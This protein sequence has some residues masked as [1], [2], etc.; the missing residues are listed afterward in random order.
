MKEK[1]NLPI[2]TIHLEFFRC[3]LKLKL[4][5]LS[6]FRRIINYPS[7]KS[8]LEK[9]V[10]RFEVL[11]IIKSFTNPYS[12]KKYI[13]LTN[14]GYQLFEHQGE[15][16]KFNPETALHDAM[17]IELVSALETHVSFYETLITVH[18]DKKLNPD[19]VLIK[20]LGNSLSALAIE[21]EITQKS[22]VRIAEKIRNY[23]SNQQYH[24][25]VYVFTNRNIMENYKKTI[26]TE[27]GDEAFNKILLFFNS[28]VISRKFDIL[29]TIGSPRGSPIGLVNFLNNV[30]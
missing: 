17:V 28:S 27:F 24:H 8:V 12:R 29:E 18:S 16:F 4:I 14:L 20:R 25:V 11:G 7:H 13:Y 26:A 15:R 5:S 21:L 3:L 30:I 9:I 2:N 19:A 6:S 22:K 1:I 10:R 23:L